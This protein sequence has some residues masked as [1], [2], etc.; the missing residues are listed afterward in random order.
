METQCSCATLARKYG[1]QANTVSQRA[2]KEKWSQGRILRKVEDRLPK[3]QVQ[4]PQDAAETRA[5]IRRRAVEEGFVLLDELRRAYTES[6]QFDRL[7]ALQKVVPL[8]NTVVGAITKA[9]GEKGIGERAPALRIEFLSGVQ[10][11][12]PGNIIEAEELLKTG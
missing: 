3:I 4:V 7:Q 9:S 11:I 10:P 8:W 1:L 5:M 12:E 6:V 2:K